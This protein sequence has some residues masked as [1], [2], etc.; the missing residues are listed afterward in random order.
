MGKTKELGRVTWDQEFTEAE[1][2]TFQEHCF[3]HDCKTCNRIRDAI[4]REVRRPLPIVK[5]KKIIRRD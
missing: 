3:G 5:K 2:K 1:Y 4:H